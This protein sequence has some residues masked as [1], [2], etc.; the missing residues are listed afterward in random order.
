MHTNLGERRIEHIPIFGSRHSPVPAFKEGT[1]L[2]SGEGH[3]M[4]PDPISTAELSASS[5]KH[6]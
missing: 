3:M 6:E 2:A 4:I 5:K 1:L